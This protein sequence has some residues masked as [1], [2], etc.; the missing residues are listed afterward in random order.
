LFVF[1]LCNLCC[2]FLWVVHFWLCCVFVFLCLVYPMLSGS[3]GCPLLIVLCICFSLSCVLYVVRFIGN[4]KKKN[5]YTT[6]LIMD[7]PMNLTT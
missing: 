2:Q 7:N 5:K 4:K 1:V 6:Q 3:L